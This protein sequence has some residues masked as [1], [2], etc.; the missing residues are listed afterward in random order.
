MAQ[1]WGGRFTGSINEL[2]WNFNAS[3]TFDKRFL[4]VDV[5]GS[6]AHATMLAKQG[7]ITEEE[8]DLILKGLD[9]ILEDVKAGKLEIS[10]STKT[11]TVFLR[12]TSSR[13]W[14][15]P[16]RRYTRDAVVTI[17]LLLI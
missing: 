6:K 1:L 14:E 16:A 9:S 15:M 4:E 7:I 10:T 8:R 3:I 12:L 2:A 13:E 17:R 11:S 5:K